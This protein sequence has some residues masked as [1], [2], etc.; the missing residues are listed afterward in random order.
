MV[1]D[2]SRANL[3][4]EDNSVG[5]KEEDYHFIIE[6]FEN[7]EGTRHVTF[8]QTFSFI[9]QSSIPWGLKKETLKS[10]KQIHR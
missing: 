5:L 4:L 6:F 7:Q 2:V 9:S 3:L 8:L 10:Y 1:A